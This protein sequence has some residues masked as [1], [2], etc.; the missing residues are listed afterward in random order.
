[1]NPNFSKFSESIS[2]IN[3]EQES[4][5]TL[6]KLMPMLLQQPQIKQPGVVSSTLNEYVCTG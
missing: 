4:K 6:T 1:M 2:A 5:Q 3:K